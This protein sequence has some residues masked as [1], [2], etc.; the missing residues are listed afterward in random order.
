MYGQEKENLN[1]YRIVIQRKNSLCS[2]KELLTQHKALP[3][4][5]EEGLVLQYLAA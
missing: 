3:K 1:F 4:L 2:V 5:K